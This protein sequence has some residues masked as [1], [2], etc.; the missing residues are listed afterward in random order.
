MGVLAS[1]YMVDFTVAIPT[2]NGEFRL[3]EV[4]ERLRS[5]TQV[6]SL[7][8]E[9]IVVDNNST[10]RTAQ[11]VQHYQAISPV[12]LRY[13]L[14]LRQGAAF[15]RKR[16][17]QE[18]HSSLVGFLDD[19]NLPAL[20]WV[21]DAYAFAQAHPRAG[22]WGSRIQGEFEVVP[23]PEFRRILPF[24]ALVDRGSHPLQYD[25]RKRLL[26]PS[27][28]LVIRKQAWLDTVPDHT[29]LSGRVQ[30]NMLTGEDLEAIAY[31]QQSEW[32][33]WYNPAMQVTHKIPAGRLQKTYLLPFFRGIGLSRYITRT[34]GMRSLYKPFWAL[35][36]MAND[37]RKI[38]VHVV[39]HG[40]EIK[41]NVV[42]ACE[43]QLLIGSFLSPLYLYFNG[44]LNRPSN[45]SP[46]VE[47]PTPKQSHPDF[48]N[49]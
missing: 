31:I 3:A 37:L 13:Y 30:G 44:Y 14:E 27:A 5:Q 36:Y 34:V 35:A 42:V 20:G 38:L 4:L 46:T 2:Y 49:P 25:P 40:A 9:I 17:I 18:A 39:K 15:A 6:G 22:A 10:D 12:P 7:T 28:G 19:D 41:T 16:A 23:P 33:V 47:T 45:T 29:R 43:L 21:A 1:A 8:W 32:E 48:P 11:V 26:P 24:L